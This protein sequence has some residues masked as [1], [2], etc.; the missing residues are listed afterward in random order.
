MPAPANMPQHVSSIHSTRFSQGICSRVQSDCC[1]SFKITEVRT[2]M[3]GNICLEHF[4]VQ[5]EYSPDETFTLNTLLAAIVL[6]TM[7]DKFQTWKISC[8]CDCKTLQGLLTLFAKY[9]S[10]FDRSTCII[11]ALRAYLEFGGI[12]H[13]FRVAIPRNPTLRFWIM[14]TFQPP[15]D[16]TG[17][18]PC[19][20]RMAIPGTLFLLR[21]F[22]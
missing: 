15:A 7:A 6:E 5:Q 11:S 13:Q 21:V 8:P 2:D 9:F 17:L 19:H 10:P 22:K 4:A 20:K 18:S 14:R 12:H 3:Q 16:Q 1:Q